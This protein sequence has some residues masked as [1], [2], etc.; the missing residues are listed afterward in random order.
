MQLQ[1]QAYQT[2]KN[3]STAIYRPTEIDSQ[4]WPP[5]SGQKAI[6]PTRAARVERSFRRMLTRTLCALTWA[7]GCDRCMLCIRVSVLK[8]TESS[9]WQRRENDV[10]RKR[11][12]EMKMSDISE[13]ADREENSAQARLSLATDTWINKGIIMKTTRR[14]PIRACPAWH[15]SSG[16]RERG[17][18]ELKKI[19]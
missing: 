5:K 18:N 6:W 3:H 12:R 8:L 17:A 11:E 16:G 1:L 13:D 15:Q 2:D 14:L 4:R 19:R 9:T 7:A 10:S